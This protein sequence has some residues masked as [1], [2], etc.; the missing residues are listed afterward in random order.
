MA[1]IP[2]QHS[3][4]KVN[5]A[6]NFLADKKPS[7]NITDPDAM[8]ILSNWRLAHAY[9]LN[10]FYQSL[11]I[12][13]KGVDL[14]GLVGQRLKRAP[15]IIGKLKRYDTMKLSQMQDIGGVR[16]VV[17]NIPKVR[18]L[19]NIYRSP[20]FNHELVHWDDY[21]NEPKKDGYRGLHLIF[22]YRSAKVDDFNNL[23]IEVQLRTKTQHAWATAVETMDIYLGQ[24]LKL[25]KGERKWKKFFKYTSMAF[26]ILE[27]SNPVP[28]LEKIKEKE[29]FRQV[30]LMNKEL[31]V[32]DKL[33]G[34]SIATDKILNSPKKGVYNLVKLDLDKKSL[35]ILRYPQSKLTDASNELTRLEEMHANNRN[36]DVVLLSAG[37]LKELKKSY[38]NY[39]LDT[40]DFIK[41]VEKVIALS[42]E[43]QKTLID[44]NLY[45]K[46]KPKRY[47]ASHDFRN[48]LFS[49]DIPQADNLD[50]VREI[51]EAVKNGFYTHQEIC[52][53]TD[54]SLR[55]VQYKISSAIILGFIEKTEVIK[56]TQKGKLWLLKD[57]YS[58]AESKFLKQ[59][60]EKTKVY[61][62]IGQD[63]FTSKR[64]DRTILTKRIMDHANLSESTARRRA[65]TL[66]AWSNKIL[67]SVIPMD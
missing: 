12:R 38:P 52:S 66:I 58:S 20:R 6:G 36:V 54:Y 19:E 60:I 10:K 57:K 51:V 25:G 15:S 22:K 42:K 11:N 53:V 35:E 26:S 44:S 21:I 39:F 48:L 55:H 56:L 49:G 1:Y 29:I 61:Q 67:Q 17:S 37:P 50:T 32:L 65:S 8:T 5:R 7:K 30:R 3:K 14:S 41:K 64:P 40:A 18:K 9:P 46:P 13:I 43:S 45:K 23:T 28:G 47:R 63:L 27:R 16:A 4:N 33:G 62:L 2:P 59:T 24:S 34:F 31:K